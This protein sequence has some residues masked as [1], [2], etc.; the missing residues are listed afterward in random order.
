MNGLMTI[1]QCEQFNLDLTDKNVKI[2]PLTLPYTTHLRAC[3]PQEQPCPLPPWPV[4]WQRAVGSRVHSGDRVQHS[5][6]CFVPLIM[7]L[8]NVN[9]VWSSRHHPPSWILQKLGTW[10]MKP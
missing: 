5:G 4:C 1:L 7:G 6:A 10:D 3:S 9:R 8:T 2:Q